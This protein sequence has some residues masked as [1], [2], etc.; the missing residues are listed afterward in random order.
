MTPARLTVAGALKEA[1]IKAATEAIRDNKANTL[2]VF[3]SK[4]IVINL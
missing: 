1:G 2:I 4:V 3:F